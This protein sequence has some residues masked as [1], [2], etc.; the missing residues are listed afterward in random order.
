MGQ[1][2]QNFLKRF[3]RFFFWIWQ[4]QGSPAQR[5]RGLALGVFSGCFPLFGFQMIFGIIL[6]G[7][8]RGNQLLAVTGTWISNPVT[9]VPLYWINYKVGSLMLGQVNNNQFSNQLTW[10][11]IWSNGFNFSIR[12]LIGSTFVG[13]CLGMLSGLI[14][15]FLLRK[16]SHL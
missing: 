5:A 4:Q 7:L 15:Y 10:E 12:I 3:R 14:V 13:I 1:P 2:R 11:N 6:A 9:Y 16:T 8:F